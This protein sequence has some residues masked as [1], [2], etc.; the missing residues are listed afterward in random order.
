MNAKAPNLVTTAVIAAGAFS[1]GLLVGQGV[2]HIG[3][4]VGA[5][6][7]ASL[8]V[9]APRPA[10]EPALGGAKPA[11]DGA[12][13]ILTSA[14]ALR[15]F[16]N[17]L[18]EGRLDRYAGYGWSGYTQLLPLVGAFSSNEFPKAWKLLDAQPAELRAPLRQA[19]AYFWS[20]IDPQAAL[21][22]GLTLPRTRDRGD[23][24]RPILSNWGRTDPQAA[25]AAARQMPAGEQRETALQSVIIGLAD[26]NPTAAR[27]LL[28]NLSAGEPL[29][30]AQVIVCCR[31]APLDAEGAAALFERAGPTYRGQCLRAV[32][33]AKASRGLP[34][35][36]AWAQTLSAPEE[37]EAALGEVAGQ[38][39][40]SEPAKAA[41]FVMSQPDEKTRQRLASSLVSA[42]AYKDG[43]AASA[44]V[45]AL[46]DGPLRKKALE[47]LEGS[48]GFQ[49]PEAV[50]NFIIRSLPPGE[51]RTSSLKQ[52]A[53]RWA[54]PGD[55]DRDALEWANGLPDG[56]ERDAFIAGACT[57]LPM[58]DPEEAIQKALLMSPG[59]AQT[60]IFK[61]AALWW[62]NRDAES[63]AAWCAA[64]PAGPARTATLAAISGSWGGRD[65]VAAG[66]WLQSLRADDAGAQAAEAYIAAAAA[67]RPDLAAQWVGS[68]PDETK[69]NEQVEI[70]ARAWL[71]TDP[72]AA[73]AWLQQ[74]SLPDK[75]KQRLLAK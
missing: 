72:A 23:L 65:P 1:L 31:L 22:A 27:L 56:P 3:R 68:I 71:R 59:K 32:A 26:Q 57:M 5:K 18:R 75:R 16:G 13:E 34:E 47:D 61:Q 64:L 38:W 4:L 28:T 37:Q 46:P 70:V 48:W 74:T 30:L 39:G 45:L 17:K 7:R 52:L 11:E 20:R 44:W 66:Q 41:D 21:A 62:V 55:G 6:E 12:S 15:V 9:G 35:A 49:D 63:A 25:L 54:R 33:R 2:K 69:R 58:M 60:G 51:E 73:Q 40:E 10:S 42:W 8:T 50:A 19:L 53:S 67:R 14:E 36:V 43:A 24:V 29:D